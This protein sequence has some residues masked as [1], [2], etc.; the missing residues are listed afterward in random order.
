MNEDLQ[1]FLLVAQEGN[2]TRTAEKLFL[3]QSALTQSIHRL[4]RQLQTK[5][6]SQ[7]GKQ[8]RLTEDGKSLVL[9]GT[10]IAQLWQ[11]ATSAEKRILNKPTYSIGMFDNV[12]LKL[13]EFLQTHLQTDEY[14]LELT[15]SSSSN[16]FTQLQ[17]N[18]LDVAFC[19]LDPAAILPKQ[20]MLLKTFSEPLLP[21]TAKQFTGELAEI[22]FILYNQGSHTRKQID[23]VFFQQGIQPI[24]F[25]ESTST[26][27]MKELALLGAGV[28]L[29]PKNIIRTELDQGRLKKQNIPLR[30]QRTYGLY[31]NVQSSLM[32]DHPLL[33]RMINTL[34]QVK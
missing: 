34:Q 14:K 23:S 5:L 25:A 22:P 33:Q 12:A 17:L 16:L 6:F 13:G 9:I 29:L 26:T 4:E 15:I 19:V 20:L 11:T 8:L 28:A 18:T 24:I 2:V 7:H 21:V 10:K 32:K 1:R 27:F 30:W 31:Y 3:T